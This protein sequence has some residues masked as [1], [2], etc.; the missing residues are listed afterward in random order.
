M[1][2]GE[3]ERLAFPG[4]PE[5]GDDGELPLEPAEPLA[6]RLERYPVRRVLSL[7]PAGAETELDPAAAHLVDLSHDDG[8]RARQPERRRT[9]QRPAPGTA[10]PP[11]PARP[12]AP[13][14]QP[15]ARP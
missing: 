7:Q 13:T 8:Q 12:A 11:G 4:G 2:P 1:R 5:P 3:G 14:R 9:H 10:R 6:E 15:A